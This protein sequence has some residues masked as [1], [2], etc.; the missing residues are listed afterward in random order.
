MQRRHTEP[1]TSFNRP[2]SLFHTFTLSWM[3]GWRRWGRDELQLQGS[4]RVSGFHLLHQLREDRG[5]VSG[6]ANAVD[7]ELLLCAHR[8]G[9]QR[10][11]PGCMHRYDRHIS[12]FR[13]WRGV[14]NF[15]WLQKS[16]NMTWA[17]ARGLMLQTY[18]RRMLFLQATLHRL[19]GVFKAQS[20]NTQRW[21]TFVAAQEH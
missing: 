16:Y 2:L 3:E 1:S 11:L 21:Q 14:L 13:K 4:S 9:Q 7:L 12:K 6:A 17:G 15:I 19:D 20:A 10:L 5:R 8:P 18:C